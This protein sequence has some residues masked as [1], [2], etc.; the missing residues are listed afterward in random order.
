MQVIEINLSYIV[1]NVSGPKR[2]QDRVPVSCVKE[3]FLNCLNE[4]ASFCA[5]GLTSKLVYLYIT[6]VYSREAAEYSM[7]YI[8]M[9]ASHGP[10]S[11]S[12]LF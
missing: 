12:N 10:N 7:N 4:K 2:P 3:D 9:T 6:V 8:N 11:C 1:P 5:L